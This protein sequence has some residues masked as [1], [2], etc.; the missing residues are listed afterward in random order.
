MTF[1]V[2]SETAATLGLALDL[3]LGQPINVTVE[4]TFDHYDYVSEIYEFMGTNGEVVTI[5]LAEDGSYVELTYRAS[6][7]ADYTFG[8]AASGIILNKVK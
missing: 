7:D 6:A 3:G 1:S 4:L 2:K 8:D 5:K